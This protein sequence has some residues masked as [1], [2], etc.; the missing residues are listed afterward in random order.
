[1]RSL[2]VAG[3]NIPGRRNIA[4]IVTFFMTAG[5]VGM[6]AQAG[7]FTAIVV[8][9]ALLILLAIVRVPWLGVLLLVASVPAQDFGALPLSG[10]TLTVTRALF[11]L[12]LLGYAVSLIVK[13]EP[14]RSS[15]ILVPYA[16]FVLIIGMSLTWA[17]SMS[18]AAAE[19]GRWMVAL[20]AFV[21]LLHFLV[22]ASERRI[23]AFMVAV[24]AAG[25]FQA[26]YGVT[27]SLFALGPESF[28]VGTQGS[29]AFGTFGQPNSYA[30]YLEM[31]FFPVFWAGVFVAGRLPESLRRY[32]IV[33]IQGFAVS[34]P[35]RR[36]LLH[37]ATLSVFLVASAVVILSGIAASYSRGA[38]LGVAAGVAI[39]ALLFHRWIR[40]GTVVLLPVAAILLLGGAST[41]A[42]DAF[43]ERI[44]SGFADLRPFD[45]SSIPVT[46]ENFA[47]AERMAHWQ[48]GW[49]MFVDNPASGVGAGN[50]NESYDDHFVREQFRFSRGHAHNYYIHLLAEN[51]IPGLAAYVTLIGSL[52][53]LGLRVILQAH[54]GLERMLALGAFG[55]IVSVSVH[56]VF[57]NLHVLNLSLHLG[58]I[59]ALTIAA[60]RRWQSARSRTPAEFDI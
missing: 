18:A 49:S 30:G 19:I 16:A 2:D 6:F 46:D 43:S 59:W 24:A 32:Q 34:A 39:T 42:P 10:Q 36:A 11:P 22:G 47:A 41:V 55:T 13:R 60:H 25:V 45:A 17:T 14:L 48:A 1:M 8:I 29:R 20:V 12:A 56:N 57:E 51:G 54:S 31:V 4:W 38:W 5:I 23:L 33:R 21:V 53:F 26:T 52:M 27:Q 7:V 40:R 3:F 9:G 35:A 28:R 15:R 58:L 44:A 37:Q 50:F